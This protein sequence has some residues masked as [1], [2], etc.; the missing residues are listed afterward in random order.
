[1]LSL[2]RGRPAFRRLFVAHSISRAGDAFNTVALVVLAFRL[3]GSGLGVAATVAFEVLPVLLF[4]PFIGFVVD[5]VSRRRVM[6]GSD[7]VRAALAGLL[8]AVPGSIGVAYLVAFGLATGALLFNPASVSLIPETVDPDELVDANSAMWTVAVLAQIVLAPVAGL[9][10]ATSGVRVAFAVNALSYLASAAVLRRLPAG[11]A[12]SSGE[13]ASRKALAAG[14]RVVRSDA[15]LT[16]LAVVQVLAA[17]SA[18]ATGGLLVVLA[19]EAL[20]VGPSGFGFLLAAIGGGATVGPLVLRRRIRPGRR[21]WLFGPYAVRGGVDLTLAATADAYVAGGALVLYGTATSTGTIAYHSTLQSLV[22]SATR[23]RTMTFFDL[24]WNT[25]R[26][27]SLGLGGLLA[28]TVGIRAVYAAAGAVLVVSA[29][30]GALRPLTSATAA[31]GS[32]GPE[33]GGDLR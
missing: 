6:V 26:L 31:S 28:D 25:A 32:P 20:D 14:F 21:S 24:L 30:Y 17:L 22:P 16:R 10:I 1:V 13:R 8:V 2:V 11:E 27:T 9:L 19:A 12:G 3:T 23:G 7:L 4:G 15:L 18:G 33:D 5:R 29:A